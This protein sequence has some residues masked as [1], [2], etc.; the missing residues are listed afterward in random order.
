MPKETNDLGHGSSPYFVPNCPK[1]RFMSNHSIIE[2]CY[3]VP[4][5]LPVFVQRLSLLP[6]SATKHSCPIDGQTIGHTFSKR[7]GDFMLTEVKGFAARAAS[8]NRRTTSVSQSTLCCNATLSSRVRLY[9]STNFLSSEINASRLA[10]VLYLRPL[11][12]RQGSV[13]M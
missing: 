4:T 1:F 9:A 11:I 2:C 6:L 7:I 12:K 5:P 3:F 8:E 13:I 10:G